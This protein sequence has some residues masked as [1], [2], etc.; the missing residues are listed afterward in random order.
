[1]SKVSDDEAAA[2]IVRLRASPHK[3]GV[4]PKDWVSVRRNLLPICCSYLDFAAARELPVLWTRILSKRIK[5]VSATDIHADEDLKRGAADAS[6]VGWTT[7]DV[8]DCLIDINK[9]H[10]V[11]RGAF[12]LSDKKPRAIIFEHAGDCLTVQEAHD[13]GIVDFDSLPVRPLVQGGA[14]GIPDDS[15][16]FTRENGAV[17]H[18]HMQGRL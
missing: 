8:D 14:C 11:L 10:A 2:M 15:S 5:G 7:D 3:K 13:K 9:E 17:A 16:D 6:V 4:D 1:M 12:A 18:L